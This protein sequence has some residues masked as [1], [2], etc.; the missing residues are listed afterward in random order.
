MIG[1]YSN[2]QNE[3]LKVVLNTILFNTRNDARY[4]IRMRPDRLEE[5]R[6]EISYSN[7]IKPKDYMPLDLIIRPECNLNCKY[8]YIAQ[9]GKELYPINERVSNETIL[10]NI[11]NLLHY[12]YI[13]YNLFIEDF[14]LF[15]GDLFYDC[16]LFDVLDVFYKHMSHQHELYG[17][18][19]TL[20]TQYPVT[21][22]IPTNGLFILEDD[23]V[24]RFNEYFEK[25]KEIGV[26]LYLSIS[27]DG[28]YVVN[29]REDQ[30]LPD[31]YFDKLFKFCLEKG[32]FFHPMI[33]ADNIDNWI[34]NYDWWRDK[35]KEYKYAEAQTD[36]FLPMMLEVRNDNW[37][38]EKVDKY[39]QLLDHMIDD[40]FKMC[41]ND[42]V[43]FTKHLYS[44]Y[45][46]D[47]EEGI[48]PMLSGYD[49]VLL[50][51]EEECQNLLCTVQ[52]SLH[53]RMNDL[54]IVPCHRT[55]YKQFEA[56]HFITNPEDGKIIGFEAGNL[57]VWL[58]VL[59]IRRSTLPKCARC[60]IQPFCVSGCLGAQYEASGEIFHP[61]DSVCLLFMNKI[62]YQVYKF[63]QMGVFEVAKKLNHFSPKQQKYIE[64]IKQLD[65]YQRFKNNE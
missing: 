31:D 25:F 1:T 49:P 62:A 65:V 32:Y 19:Y 63:E 47:K 8:C 57:S 40:R 15:S 14:H 45:T 38:Y 3:L 28:K 48:L 59:N 42:I 2:D 30:E 24:E 44:I 56:G 50:I 35:L 5:R 22:H 46:P 37:T 10:K 43:K 21:I 53:I 9:H 52:T 39:I 36:H 16:F 61:I 33:G 20:N 29:T 64:A 51:N 26:V 4:L 41:D 18:L 12:I 13:R 7:V 6:A 55:A 34:E 27:T 54:T 17:Q 60:V 23:K 58:M 11:N